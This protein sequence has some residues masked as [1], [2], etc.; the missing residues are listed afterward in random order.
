M[1]DR[2]QPQQR[3]LP[4]SFRLFAIRLLPEYLMVTEMEDW[5]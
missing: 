2:P 3:L 5:V 4:S 1:S